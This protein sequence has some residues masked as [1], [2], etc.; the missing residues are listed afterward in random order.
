MSELLQ[1]VNPSSVIGAIEANTIESFL[2]WTKWDKLELYK[3]GDDL[4]INSDIPFFIYNLVLQTDSTSAGPASVV[5]AAIARAASRQVPM[6]WWLSPSEPVLEMGQHLEDKGFFHAASLT[7]LAA[8]LATLDE[9]ATSPEGL[10]IRKVSS[11]ADLETWCLIMTEVSEFPDF[12]QTAWLEMYQGMDITNDQQW[13]LYLGS[14]DGTPVSTSALFLGAGVAGIHGV[15]TIPE[16]RG[17]GIGGVMTHKPL[18]DARSQGYGVGVLYSSEMALGI[19]QKLG[20]QEFG[21]GK[22]YLWMP[23]EE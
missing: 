18:L 8:E 4:W 6:A 5:D 2:T 21:E 7:A 9:Q 23:P 16:Y 20:F 1:E 17:R 22:I 12:V 3:D 11:S 13:H 14:V 15:T 19:Y 10:T